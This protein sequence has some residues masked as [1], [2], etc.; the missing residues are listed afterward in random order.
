MPKARGLN[1]VDLLIHKRDF[2]WGKDYYGWFNE[3]GLV[4]TLLYSRYGNNKKVI[5]IHKLEHNSSKLLAKFLEAKRKARYFVR[6][7]NEDYQ[8][9]DIQFMQENGFRRYNRSF[10]FEFNTEEEI[11]TSSDFMCRDAESRDLE[12]LCSIEQTSQI[13]EYR[14]CLFREKSFL[15]DNLM[16]IYVIADIQNREKIFAYVIKRE[17]E[18]EHTYEF[19]LHSSLSEMLP[20]F[21]NTFAERY[22]RFEK[23]S[24][25]RFIVNESHKAA[26]ES[27]KKEHKLITSS[28]L[29]I[30]E[31]APRE[32]TKKLAK[33]YI[34]RTMPAG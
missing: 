8:I 33:S 29:L 10:Y 6:E 11:Q 1:P 26:L 5:E 14:D 12:E 3:D 28:Q 15:K 34:S 24:L 2:L 30:K 16:N 23:N 7:L 32:K 27:F 21:L 17:T 13:L 19:I 9:E 18:N 25:F 20:I 22:I 4:N 31:S